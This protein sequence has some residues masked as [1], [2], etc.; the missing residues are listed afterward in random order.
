[1]KWESLTGPDFEKAVK[2]TGVCLLPMGIIERHGSHLPLGTDLIN[3]MAICERS[4]EIEPA[5]V[6]PQF[7]FGQ[8]YEAKCF[9]GTIT[10][11][12]AFLVEFI[13][14]ILDEIGRNGFK[15]VIIVNGHGGNGNLIPFIAQ[16]MLEKDRPYTLYHYQ[17]DYNSPKFDKFYKKYV[18]AKSFDDHGGEVET[19]DTMANAP[20]WV[21]LERESEIGKDQKRLAR[22][23]KIPRETSSP[24][25]WY[26][27]APEHM[28]GR[29]AGKATAEKGELFREFC[30]KELVRFMKGVKKDEVSPALTKEFYDKM[31]KV[32]R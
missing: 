19:S 24:I 10:L 5:V 2:K 9:A 7:Y 29:H 12:P 8:I 22:W 1:M 27:Y 26:A 4:A 31:K 32:G 13:L 3:V 28:A 15:K 18:F 17:P 16:C 14:K 11:P 25:W 21:K 6:F 20:D 23:K 30:A